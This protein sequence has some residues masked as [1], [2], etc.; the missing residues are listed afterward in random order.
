MASP[1]H[2]DVADGLALLHVCAGA[3][4]REARQVAIDGLD[5][6]AVIDLDDIAVAALDAAEAQA[7][8]AC[9]IAPGVPMG[10]A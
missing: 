7:A 9:G 8:G 4:R 3:Q 2:A 6:L 1:A 5:A 10:A